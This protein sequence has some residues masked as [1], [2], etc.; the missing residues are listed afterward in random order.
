MLWPLGCDLEVAD[1]DA[2]ARFSFFD[3]ND[4]DPVP[5]PR[6]GYDQQGTVM[7]WSESCPLTGTCTE[8]GLEFTWGPVLAPEKYEPAW[9]VEFARNASGVPKRV[10]TTAV[11]SLCPWVLWKRLRMSDRIHWGRLAVYVL[12]LLAP[13]LGVYLAEQTAVALRVRQIIEQE[14]AAAVRYNQQHLAMLQNMQAAQASPF[15][16]QQFTKEI[17]V[18]SAFLRSQPVSNLSLHESIV[19]A[20]LTPWSRRSRGSYTASPW[21]TAPYPSPAELHARA[22]GVEASRQEVSSALFGSP[23]G[24]R[25]TIA[26]IIA[27]VGIPL[28]VLFLPLSRSLARVRWVHVTRILLYS[29]IVPMLAMGLWLGLLT[30]HFGWPDAPANVLRSSAVFGRW[31]LLIL[32]N[33]WWIIA[34]RRY[35]HMPRGWLIAP[36]FSLLSVLLVGG[37][38]YL[39]AP[40]LLIDA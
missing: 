20:V 37:M 10:V 36:A 33:V 14:H 13:M 28:G 22:L 29:A 2:M 12:I 1:G 32:I 11:V 25:W 15:L 16:K 39:I 18:T 7:H 6:C 24:W 19:E 21:G 30:I 4:G 5:C 3:D 17:D 31:S 9:C 40:D 8:C 26:G 38:I 23:G 27:F 34:I 35:L